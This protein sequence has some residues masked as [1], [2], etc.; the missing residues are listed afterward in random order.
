MSAYSRPLVISLLISTLCGGLWAQRAGNNASSREAERTAS[1]LE[2]FT[3]RSDTRLVDL[4]PRLSTKEGHLVLNL[5][6]SAF[7]V[8]ENGAKQQITMFRH[9]DVPVSAGAGH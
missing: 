8:Y 7:T 3:F 2:E 1:L 6:K 5:P 9:E 4:P